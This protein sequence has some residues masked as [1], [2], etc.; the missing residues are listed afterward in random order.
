MKHLFNIAMVL[1]LTASVAMAGNKKTAKVG[2]YDQPRNLEGWTLVWADEFNGNELDKDSWERCPRNTADWGRHMSKLDSLVKVE[3]GVLKLYGI[4]RPAEVKDNVPYLTG[5]VQSRRRHSMQMGRFDVRARFDSGQ[6]FWPAIWLMPDIR[7]PW[8]TGGEIDI[9]EHLNSEDV[10]YQ[11]VH[12]QHTVKQYDPYIKNGSNSPINR[13]EFNVYSVEIEEDAIKFYI[14]GQPTF[15]YKKVPGLKSQ[16]PYA[17]HPFYVILS[18]QLGG[19]WVGK[20]DPADLPVRMDV[21]YV[22]FY[23]PKKKSKR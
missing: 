2:G 6:G 13:N 16:F 3:D 17:G 20:V 9:M 19:S 21:D 8:P 12:S 10:A 15:T 7:I 4:N 18:A 23:Q 14:N 22:R 1:M 5:G 11:T